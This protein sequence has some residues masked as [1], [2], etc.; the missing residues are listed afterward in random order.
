MLKMEPNRSQHP[1]YITDI[2]LSPLAQRQLAYLKTYSSSWWCGTGLTIFTF[3]REHI[4]T[5]RGELNYYD[6]LTCAADGQAATPP[7]ASKGREGYFIMGTEHAYDV[8]VRVVR[9][10]FLAIS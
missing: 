3:K 4:Q 10:F 6:E 8:V 1:T 9:G 2:C 5:T 7:V